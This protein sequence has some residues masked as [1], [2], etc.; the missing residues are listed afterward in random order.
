[1]C[2]C[3]ILA[4]PY[5]VAGHR[6]LP[7]PQPPEAGH[8]EIEFSACL[9]WTFGVLLVGLARYASFPPPPPNANAGEQPVAIGCS[10]R[11]F[12]AVTREARTEVGPSVYGGRTHSR[13]IFNAISNTPERVACPLLGSGPINNLRQRGEDK[14][15]EKKYR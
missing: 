1:M 7:L 6:S 9:P 8:G 4:L 13:I 5:N 3:G 2:V 14:G 10:T 11:A 15:R 12:V